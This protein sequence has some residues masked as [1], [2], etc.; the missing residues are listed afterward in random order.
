MKV[1]NKGFTL[2]EVVLTVAIFSILSMVALSIFDINNIPI[3]KIGNEYA[4]QTQMRIASDRLTKKIRE[5]TAI[6]VHKNV[7]SVF[8]EGT[9]ADFE[10][11]ALVIDD[12]FINSLPIAERNKLR[13]SIEKY[14]GWNFITLDSDGRELRDFIYHKDPDNPETGYYSMERILEKGT[15][16]GM[17]MVY[18]IVFSKADDKGKN[19]FGRPDSLEF[20]IIGKLV[21]GEGSE[22]PVKVEYAI[23]ALSSLQVVDKGDFSSAATVIFYRTE[24]RPMGVDAEVAVTMILDVSGSMAWT[25]GGSTSSSNNAN[26]S[27]ASRIAILKSRAEQLLDEFSSLE[28]ANISL[29]PFSTSANRPSQWRNYKYAGKTKD[30]LDWKNAKTDNGELKDLLGKLAAGGGTNVGDGIRKAYYKLKNYEEE[31]A[32]KYMILLMDGVPTFGSVHKINY[33]DYTKTIVRSTNSKGKPTGNIPETTIYNGKTY[34]K[35]SSTDN[36]KTVTTGSG[37]NRKTTEQYVDTSVLYRYYSD[38]TFVE[39][40]IDITETELKITIVNN[41]LKTDNYNNYPSGRYAGLGNEVDDF[42][43]KPYITKMAEKLGEIKDEDGESNLR[44]FVIG[45]SDVPSERQELE[46]IKQQLLANVK[47]V[48]TYEVVSSEGLKKVFYDIRSIIVQDYWAITGPN[49]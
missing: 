45:F 29:I 34:F 40:D 4:L 23:K 1:R 19:E 28:Y 42:I 7:D 15:H 12:T 49:E 41:Q 30:P 9:F 14:R 24:E 46:F 48:S 10:G 33:D 13:D 27:N 3:A 37:N 31:E 35:V 16:E 38:A 6:F 21:G 36:Y 32:A 2:V 47:E 17:D 39:S 44:V 43:S 5:A 25:M 11:S 26:A 20:K 18:E 22:N 8:T